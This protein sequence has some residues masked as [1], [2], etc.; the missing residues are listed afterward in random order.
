M[1]RARF[2]EKECSESMWT[3]MYLFEFEFRSR[4]SLGLQPPRYFRSQTK[5]K[6]IASYP[7]GCVVKHPWL[8]SRQL[9]CVANSDQETFPSLLP[10]SFASAYTY[11]S[12]VALVRSEY[13]LARS[14]ISKDPKGLEVDFLH[15]VGVPRL[16]SRHFEGGDN[17][18]SRW[19]T[20]PSSFYWV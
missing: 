5:P 2:V 9:R 14:M 11:L 18:R 20:G 1:K 4:L 6:S 13:G 8:C 3:P 19:A 7:C 10:S 12:W 17:Q 15:G 16:W